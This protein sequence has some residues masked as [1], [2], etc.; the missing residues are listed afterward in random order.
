MYTE[1]IT[2]ASMFTKCVS[3]NATKHAFF[4]VTITAT[5]DIFYGNGVRMLSA[6]FVNRQWFCLFKN[7]SHFGKENKARQH[8]HMGF[9]GNQCFENA[10]RLIIE[11]LTVC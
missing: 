3:T 5:I 7:N 6:Y 11:M 2:I 1:F 4:K 9:Y 8:Q 10:V